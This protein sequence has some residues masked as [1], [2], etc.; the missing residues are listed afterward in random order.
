MNIVI[1]LLIF[2]LIILIHEFGHFVLAKANGIFVT[3]FSLGMGRRLIS[4]VPTKEGYRLRLLMSGKEYEK[5]ES[6]GSKTVYS[7]K[8]LPFGGSCMM[9]GEDEN[10]NDNR[11]FNK[12]GVWGRISVV[13]AGAFFNFIL[14][15]ALAIAV[16][17]ILG[18]DSPIITRVSK[19]SAAYEA[20]LEEGDKI[21]KINNKRIS[22]SR[23]ASAYFLF[24][25]LTEDEVTIS[26]ER[27]GKVQTTTLTPKYK[28]NYILGFTYMPDSSPATIESLYEGYPMDGAGLVPGD[29]ITG[30]DGTD[31]NT[32]EE[33]TNYLEEHP[34]DNNQIEL[35]YS[36]DGK[37]Q[38]VLI[39]PE[40]VGEGYELGYAMRYGYEDASILE[41]IK[42]SLV[43]IKYNIWVA[44]KSFGMLL[45][46]QAG[47]NDIAGPV[48][49]VNIIGDT[50]EASKASGGLVVFINLA[51]L[52]IMLSA[53]VGVINLLPI[54]ALD[55]GRLVFLFLE[56]VRGKPIPAEKEG[57]V[58]FIGIMALMFLMIFVIF[59][60][61]RKVLPF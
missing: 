23:E 34:L 42:Y 38:V 39:T 49:I 1:A 41:V 5:I 44:L 8:L 58:H 25:P 26:F 2:G 21:V 31:I 45:T 11:A 40:Y 60:D 16:I 15:F 59:N 12:K 3:E 20:G 24:S 48:G 33:L 57:M 14:A 46:G 22:V 19:N 13:F 56:L 43:E 30:F 47:A 51:S 10:V 55:G 61:I 35:R 9:L 50:Y 18:Y 53:N 7:L 17:G 28:E 37:E 54:P 36:R 27:D 32:G 52:T 4:L 6:Q 29:I